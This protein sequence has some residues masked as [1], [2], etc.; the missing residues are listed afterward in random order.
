MRKQ[1]TYLNRNAVCDN[2]HKTWVCSLCYPFALE[3]GK[4]YG[5]YS[6]IYMRNTP[7]DNNMPPDYGDGMYAILGGQ[8]HRDDEVAFFKD[9]PTYTYDNEYKLLDISP[10]R[11][12][13]DLG[14]AIAIYKDFTDIGAIKPNLNPYEFGP[15]LIKKLADMVKKFEQKYGKIEEYYEVFFDQRADWLEDKRRK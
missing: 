4:I 15:I 14:D 7:L 12:K 3:I 13:I 8:G 9:K 11:I 2:H 6:L 1:A 10:G 5:G